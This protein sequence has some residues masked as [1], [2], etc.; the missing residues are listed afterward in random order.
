METINL[1]EGLILT[2][3]SMIVVF[4]ILGAIWG[5]TELI[6]NI[7][8]DPEEKTQLTDSPTTDDDTVSPIDIKNQSLVI[9]EKNQKAAEIMAL[10]LAAED[11]PNK[12]FEI[13]ESERIK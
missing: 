11:Q 10:I 8:G 9:N 1:T 4:I 5:L 13:I 3:V 2:L 12:K 7:V 6:A